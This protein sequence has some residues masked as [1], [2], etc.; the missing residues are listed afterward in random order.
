MGQRTDVV[1]RI[2]GHNDMSMESCETI[3]YINLA[4]L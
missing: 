4:V 3:M 1:K 2:L